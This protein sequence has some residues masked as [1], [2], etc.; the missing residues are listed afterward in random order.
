MYKFMIR[1]GYPL[2]D[3]LPWEHPLSNWQGLCNRLEEVQRGLSRHTVVFVNYDGI[4]FAIK[5][6]PGDTGRQSAMRKKST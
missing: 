4:L 6:L 3:D 1:E 5:E 2:F